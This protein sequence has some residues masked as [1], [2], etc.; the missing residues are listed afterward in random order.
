MAGCS[1]EKT[2]RISSERT[3]Q[4]N[5]HHAGPQAETRTLERSGSVGR[6]HFMTG[7]SRAAEVALEPNRSMSSSIL[8]SFGMVNLRTTSS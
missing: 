8:D 4:E 6:R 1:S 7:E 3:K 5:E 2:C